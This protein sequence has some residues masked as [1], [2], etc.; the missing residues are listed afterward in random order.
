[1]AI[2]IK[3]Y[4]SDLVRQLNLRHMDEPTR[5]QLKAWQKDGRATGK[6]KGW[7]PD[8]EL[9]KFD[10]ADYRD[11]SSGTIRDD[12]ISLQKQLILL[13]RDLKADS[14]L[15]DN[16]DVQSFLNDFYG[17]NKAIPLF[18]IE[19]ITEAPQIASYIT[20]SGN[21]A[22]LETALNVKQEDLIKLA[23]ALSNGD[24]TKDSKA[25]KT[26]DEFLTGMKRAI[27]SH[28][29]LLNDTMGSLPPA[30]IN[31]TEVDRKY[32]EEIVKYFEEQGVG[33][34]VISG[35]NPLTVSRI[36]M[37]AQIKDAFKYFKMV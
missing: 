20:K 32:A 25:Q 8:A 23:K 12:L 1:M 26:L 27:G 21:A 5:A 30:W 9:P 22:K 14:S 3:K 29:S 19:P 37:Q 36:A 28:N 15:E 7:D 24:Y 10:D 35:D 11:S 17:D 16:K 2:D 34:K 18:E 4:M 13:G 33:I 31:S 6:Q